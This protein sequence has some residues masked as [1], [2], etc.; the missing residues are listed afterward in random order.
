[1]ISIRDLT[2]RY[3]RLAA[4]DGVTFDVEEGAVFALLGRNGA[5]KSTLLRAILGLR[6]PDR[7]EIRVAALDPWRRRA[8]LMRR[9]AFTP[10]TPD[11]PPE[12]RVDAIARFCAR[13]HAA[14][15]GAGFDE[16]MRRFEIAGS[17]RFGKLSRGQKGL[18]HLALAL[19]QR[20]RLLLLDDPTLGLD[21]VAR[22]YVFD[23]VID[24][25]AGR[26]TTILLATH[27]LEAVE[28]LASH[29][30]LLHSGRCLVVGETEALRRGDGEGGEAL[31]L[32]ELFVRST[33][34]TSE[35]RA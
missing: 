25:L 35:V 31:P 4:L 11:A 30:A 10:E 32:E 6:R 19:A 28:R 5:G 23:E 16:R 26:G 12:M 21:P 7:G 2:V 34:G 8:E 14:W 9:L 17:R 1:M 33:A 22:R 13:F 27:D 24:E 18:V 3:G 20:P 29:V 15:D